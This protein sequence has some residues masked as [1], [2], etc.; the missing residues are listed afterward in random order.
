MTQKI[1]WILILQAWA[2]L[3]VVVGHAPL[4]SIDMIQPRYVEILYRIAYSFH[5]PLF[6]F[7]SGYLFYMTRISKP[8]PYAKMV[9]DKLKRLGIPFLFFT[10]VAMVVKT[11]FASDMA[12]PSTI[13]IDEFIR[14]VVYPGEG[15][16]GELW[17]VATIFWMFLL[18]PVWA[19]SLKNGYSSICTL[20]VLLLIRM[21]TP[22]HSI[23]LLCISTAMRYAVF[24]YM[25]MCFSRFVNVQSLMSLKCG[26]VLWGSIILIGVEMVLWQYSL[27]LLL[28]FTG[29]IISI[30]VALLFDRYIPKIFSLFRNYTYQIYLMG[31]FIQILVKMLYKRD[32]FPSY[33]WGYALCILCGLYIPVLIAYIARKLDIGFIKLCL[34]LSK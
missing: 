21:V 11:L 23:E 14:S 7:V 24:F 19:W 8:M 1:N 28:A 30:A 32:I 34:G 15:P 22:P 17:F 27:A 6:I 4:L 26:Y 20:I 18:K 16:L 33:F 29:I 31:I 25:G 5:M 10:M 13:S 2:M 3:W 12:R 9:L